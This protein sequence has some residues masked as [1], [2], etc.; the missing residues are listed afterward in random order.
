MHIQLKNDE[1]ETL[2]Q[3]YSSLNRLLRIS[4]W[5]LRWRERRSPSPKPAV[6]PPLRPEELQNAETRWIKVAQRHEFG[7]EISALTRGQA[8][9]TSSHLRPMTPFLDRHGILR[10]PIILPPGS[11]LT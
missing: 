7:T 8:L 5:C 10:H 1:K 2:L 9:R 6:T 11:R 3:R 4:A